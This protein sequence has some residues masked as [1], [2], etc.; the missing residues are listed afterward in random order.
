MNV[1]ILN[2]YNPY[3]NTKEQSVDNQNL[4]QSKDRFDS[5]KLK[6]LENTNNRNVSVKA[7]N[8]IITQ[9]ER[10]YFIQLFPENLNSLKQHIVF[11]R[12]GK[13]NTT[14]LSKGILVDGK[15]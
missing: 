4:E 7:A 2:S 9:N 12:N 15:V 3:I 14:N 11:D 8:D 6:Q 10:E 5:S 1:S 13:V